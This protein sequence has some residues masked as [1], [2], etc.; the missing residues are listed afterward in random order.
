LPRPHTL[1][2]PTL[3]VAV[4]EIRKLVAIQRIFLDP[5]SGDYVRKVMLGVPGSGAWRGRAGGATL[6]IAEGFE[7]ADPYSRIRG[8]PCWAS[9]G[10]RRL[11]QLVVPGGVTTLYIAEDNDAESRRAAQKAEAD[12]V[13]PG[14][15]IHRDPLP[16]RFKDWARAL[17]AMASGSTSRRCAPKEGRGA[18]A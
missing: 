7:T 15:T 2:L 3:L 5:A 6:A 17:D 18:K 4:R 13:R 10:A 11:D 14:L 8:I 1:F 12:Y 9:A 16:V